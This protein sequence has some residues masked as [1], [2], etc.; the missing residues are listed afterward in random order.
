[1]RKPFHFCVCERRIVEVRSIEVHFD[2]NALTIHSA[3]KSLSAA[4]ST[5][6]QGRRGIHFEIRL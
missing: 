4:S 1:M 5:Q 6:K 2:P 3:G